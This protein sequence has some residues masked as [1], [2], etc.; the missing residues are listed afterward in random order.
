MLQYYKVGKILREGIHGDEIEF[1]QMVDCED[2]MLVITLKCGEKIIVK[3]DILDNDYPCF[4]LNIEEV[5]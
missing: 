1:I 5:K 3:P 2:D 4:D